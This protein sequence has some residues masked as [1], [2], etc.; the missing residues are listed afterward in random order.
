MERG[1]ALERSRRARPH[2]HSADAEDDDHVDLDRNVHA[3]PGSAS[4][5]FRR[6]GRGARLG[7]RPTGGRGRHRVRLPAVARAAGHRRAARGPVHEAA[8]SCSRGTGER[9]S[10]AARDRRLLLRALPAR[11]DTRRITLA[12]AAGASRVSRTST[13]ARAATSCRATSSRG[14]CSA[15]PPCARWDLYRV[16]SARASRSRCCGSRVIKNFGDADGGR[17]PHARLSLWRADC[18]A[19]TTRPAAVAGGMQTVTS[20]LVSRRL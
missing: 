8:R 16:A 1:E 13:D 18:R 9:R 11:D 17:E 15:V 4:V 14:R 2:R 7:L 20:T 12:A 3:P 6:S 19:V 5:G 10:G